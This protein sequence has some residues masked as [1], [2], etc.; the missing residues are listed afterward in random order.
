MRI[1]SAFDKSIAERVYG[2]VIKLPL[3]GAR[4]ADVI[5]IAHRPSVLTAVDLVLAI[6]NGQTRA[7]GKR[8]EVLAPNARRSQRTPC[9]ERHSATDR[10]LAR[11]RDIPMARNMRLGTIRAHLIA[12]LSQYTRGLKFVRC[13]WA[14]TTELA[15]LCEC[16]TS[17]SLWNCQSIAD[18]G[19][20]TE[21]YP[22][23]WYAQERHFRACADGQHSRRRRTGGCWRT[24][25]V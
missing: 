11:T 25:Q 2:A 14:A 8:E 16:N 7:F 22:H 18:V 12:G 23:T 19:I 5:V 9:T 1:G 15:P 3:K 13:G 21:G 6:V 24:E 20:G 4:T 10:S 17:K